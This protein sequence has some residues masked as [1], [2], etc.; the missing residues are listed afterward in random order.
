MKTSMLISL[1]LLSTMVYSQNAEQDTVDSYTEE[2]DTIFVHVPTPVLSVGFSGGASFINPENINNHIEFENSI[3][4]TDVRTIRTPG[5]WSLWLTYRPKNIPTFLTFRAEMLR[6]NREFNFQTPSTQD[7]STPT[8]M[9]NVTAGSTY[10]IYPFSISSGAVLLK[11]R[12]KAEIGF[13]Y[14]LATIT[15]ETTTQNGG[16]SS[17]TYEG[18]G[19]GFRLSLQQVVPIEKRIGATFE[20]GYRFLFLDE[21]RDTRGTKISGIEADYSGMFLMIGI[22]YGF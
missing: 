1:C 5:Q 11:T 14:A 10:A 21:F 8:G 2:I 4:N 16:S 22:S 9:L 19:Y 17:T 15:H 20:I 7:T 18:D 3:Y 12:M 13:I 6:S